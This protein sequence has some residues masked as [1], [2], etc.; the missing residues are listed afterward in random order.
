[1]FYLGL[2]V[3]DSIIPCSEIWSSQA[4]IRDE[5]SG[6]GGRICQASTYRVHFHHRFIWVH[7][8]LHYVG[9]IMRFWQIIIFSELGF[10]DQQHSKSALAYYQ[11]PL[12]Y[13]V[14]S[15]YQ[16]SPKIWISWWQK[17][18]W[19]VVGLWLFSWSGE[20][21]DHDQ[22][23]RGWLRA[24]NCAPAIWRPKKIHQGINW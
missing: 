3:R 18:V 7:Y 19:A 4:F 12:G 6:V 9:D 1:M 21:L 22:C 15:S 17:R 2:R 13:F 20:E 10:F 16:D 23:P 14:G 24:R 11:E 5:P 8:F